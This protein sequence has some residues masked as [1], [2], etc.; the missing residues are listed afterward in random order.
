LQREV[1][2]TEHQVSRNKVKD[3][4]FIILDDSDDE[5]QKEAAVEEARKKQEQV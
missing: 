1:K 4:D 2:I 3:S 5:R